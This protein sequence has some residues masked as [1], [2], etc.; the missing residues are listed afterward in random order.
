M[1]EDS[2]TYR[3]GSLNDSSNVGKS[4]A[5]RELAMF[6]AGHLHRDD[7]L[8]LEKTTWEEKFG[9]LRPAWTVIEAAERRPGEWKLGAEAFQEPQFAV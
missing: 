3:V 5:T 9:R 1:T 7:C 6:A 4:A 8:V 2:V